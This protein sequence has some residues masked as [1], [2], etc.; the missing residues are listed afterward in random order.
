MIP[1]DA[2]AFVA[3]ILAEP[4]DRLRRLV[5]ADWLDEQGGESNAAWAGYLRTQA[6]RETTSKAERRSDL[7]GLMQQDRPSIRARLTLPARAVQDRFFHL[8]RLLPSGN[9]TVR[10]SDA[11]IPQAVVELMPESVARESL[12]IPLGLEG[13][14]LA[15]ATPTPR[16]WALA[17]R[18]GYILNKDVL[19]FRANSDDMLAAIGR[20]YGRSDLIALDSHPLPFP[21]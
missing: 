19:L 1:P 10:L 15:V 8:L 6:E 5:F 4:A 2:N 12:V 11:E 14:F 17:D 16:D 9:V 13:S 21:L 3:G 7:I 20:Q 18:L